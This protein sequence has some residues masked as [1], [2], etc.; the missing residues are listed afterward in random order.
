MTKLQYPLCGPQVCLQR[1]AC[2]TCLLYTMCVQ[3]SYGKESHQLLSADSQ[4]A[5]GK[6][7]ISVIPNRQQLLRNF[8]SA[9][10]IYKALRYK[11]RGF[12]PR[13]CHW[14]FSLT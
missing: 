9:Y 7:T 5:S 13:W 12:D 4:A 1:A 10:T 14:N 8:Y 11:G 3:T 6:A 2:L